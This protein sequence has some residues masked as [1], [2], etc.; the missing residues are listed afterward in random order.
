MRKKRKRKRRK[1][2]NSRGLA[3]ISLDV[4]DDR[5]LIS[6]RKDGENE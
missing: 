5:E 4:I 2:K 1:K 6:T 3:S